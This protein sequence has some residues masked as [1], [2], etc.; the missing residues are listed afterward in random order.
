MKL[1]KVVALC[2][3]AK[4]F[5]LFDKID[6]TGEIT[7]WLGDGSAFYPL[8]GLPILDKETLFA[9]FDIPEKQQGEISVI[10][11]EMPDALNVDDTDPT[12]RAAQEGEI[13]LLWYGSELQPL[14]TSKGITFIQ[15][16][17]LDPLDDVMGMIRLFERVTADGQ[18]YIVAKAG[19]LLAAVIMPY[20]AAKEPFVTQLETMARESRRILTLQ[21]QKSQ[22]DDDTQKSLFED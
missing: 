21:E 19:L 16:K 11:K 2:N 5:V 22:L 1:K 8:N 15:R 14:S 6:S 20:T 9:V 10:R 17:Y 7:Q 3:K 13:S 4:C 12:E 18:P